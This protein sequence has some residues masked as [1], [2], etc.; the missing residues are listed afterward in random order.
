[1]PINCGTRVSLGSQ[2]EAGE[3]TIERLLSAS[4]TCRLQGRSLFAYLAGTLA[5]NARGDPAPSLV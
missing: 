3:H 4:Q 2:S 1:V 5:A